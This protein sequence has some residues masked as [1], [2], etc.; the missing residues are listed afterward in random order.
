[1]IKGFRNRGED[2]FYSVS[3]FYKSERTDDEEPLWEERIILVSALD[4]DEAETK[5]LQLV[6]KNEAKY[7]VGNSVSVAW[8]FHQIERVFL[9][10]DI[11]DGA[12]LFCRFLKDSEAQSLLVS[13][14]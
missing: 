13:F 12:E 9:I 2:M 1:M 14:E 10:D 11:K 4:E 8:R 6:K 5:A 3:L 7:M